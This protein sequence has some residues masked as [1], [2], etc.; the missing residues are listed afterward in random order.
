MRI[1]RHS[2]SRPHPGSLVEPSVIF[3]RTPLPSGLKY[4]GP[5][6][7][8]LPVRRGPALHKYNSPQLHGWFK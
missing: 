2:A 6:G 8:A 5:Q 3:T 7:E 4:R 1:H